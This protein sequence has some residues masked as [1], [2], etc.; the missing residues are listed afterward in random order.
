MMKYLCD[1]NV[2]SELVKQKPD[3]G[4]INWASKVKLIGL[5]AI[6]VD[7]IIYGLSWHPNSRVEEWFD[8]FFEQQCQIIPVSESIARRSGE[9]RGKLRA[10]G[11]IRTQADMLIAATAAEYGLILVTR[12]TKDFENCGLG[13]LNPFS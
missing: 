11:E 13:L 7:E 12:N 1:T 6:V 5:S 2:I 3:Q 4:V 9:M 10:S 8:R